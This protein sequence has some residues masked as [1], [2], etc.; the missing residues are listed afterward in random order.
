[1]AARVTQFGTSR[2]LQAHADLFIDQARQSG[3]DIGPITVVKTTL[4]PERAGRVRAIA[5]PDGFCVQIRGFQ[6]GVAV[7][8]E[9]RV[10][11]VTRALDA[12]QDWPRLRAIFADETEI[13]I[14][15]TGETGFAL[16][17]ADRQRP[18][19][20]AV[21]AG[22]PAKLLDLLCHRYANGAAALLILPCEL[23]SHNGQALRRILAGLSADWSLAPEFS[24]WLRNSVTICD[25]LVDRIV[26]QALEPVGAVAEPYGLW[27]IRRAP[28][29]AE[30]FQHPNV[31]Y[32]DDLT[33]YLRL[34]LHILNLGHTWLAE[35]WRTENR[36][37]DETVRAI[38]SDPKVRGGLASLYA[39]EVVPGFAVHGMAKAADDYVSQ[40]LERFDNPFL[41]H[42]LSDI[43]QNHAVKIENRVQAFVDWVHGSDPTLDLPR[44]ELLVRGGA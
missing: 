43:A 36:P 44:L 32:T 30:P 14:C 21:P 16:S 40:T 4:G 10:K 8:T 42:K 3:Q 31:R 27:A 41:D 13:V 37:A 18:L 22:F 17:P 1:M 35:R 19:P 28:G 9:L 26:S 38:L 20:D 11:S 34:K 23:V 29:M 25:T 5:H 6:H 7:D 33:P 15:N 39:E 2:F 24:Q 12:A